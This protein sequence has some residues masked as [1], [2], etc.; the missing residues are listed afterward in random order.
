MVGG[1]DIELWLLPDLRGKA[2]TDLKFQLRRARK[3]IKLALFTL[4]HP[5]LCDEMLRHKH[6][7]L[8]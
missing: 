7:K 3:S 1:Q 8:R 5:D 4:T 6:A 2:L